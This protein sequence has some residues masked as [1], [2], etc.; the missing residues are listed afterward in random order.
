MTIQAFIIDTVR[1]LLPDPV[2]RSRI[3]GE[4]RRLVDCVPWPP[5]DATTSLDVSKLALLRLLY[6][7]SQARKASLARASEAVVQLARSS[8]EACLLGLY[9]LQEP[10]VV[11][12]LTAGY[13]KAMR[14]M[15]RY[16][17]DDGLVSS[18][19]VDE[20]TAAMGGAA[21]APG[22]WAMADQIDTPDDSGAVDLYRRFY[23]PTSTLFVHANA[24]SLIRHVRKDNTLS[25]RPSLPWTRRSALRISDACVGILASA[26]AANEG[27][28][29]VAFN[30]YADSHLTTALTPMAVAVTQ[31][32]RGSMQISRLPELAKVIYD[33]RHYIASAQA[34]ADTPQARETRLRQNFDHVMRLLN[35]ELPDD[36][37]CLLR[38]DFV[39]RLQES[40]VERTEGMS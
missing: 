16:L 26:I 27:K 40:I 3:R 25:D 17:A 4:A 19:V 37:V 1:G 35:L 39:N 5:D 29:T 23:V 24:A 36:I 31:F 7:Q 12:Q 6:L 21:N 18:D 9:S 8:V 22:V 11:T 13:L 32:L 33:T 34:A 2:R 14:E 20:S 15:L 10:D 30:H 38:A 28:P